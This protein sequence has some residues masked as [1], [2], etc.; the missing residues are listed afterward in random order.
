MRDG[1]TGNDLGIFVLDMSN[2]L[3]TPKA[4]TFDGPDGHL[5]VADGDEVFRFDKDTGAFIDIF[6]TMGSGGLS[7]ARDLVFLPTVVPEPASASLGLL[8][9]MLLGLRRRLAA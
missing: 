6:V 5:Y 2:G 4:L 9:V 1:A 8:S 7:E 3:G